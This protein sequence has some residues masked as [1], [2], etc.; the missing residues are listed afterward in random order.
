[1]RRGLELQPRA[2]LNDVFGTRIA[3]PSFRSECA[4]LVERSDIGCV[5][6]TTAIDIDTGMAV[7]AGNGRLE[8]P[9]RPGAVVQDGSRFAL[10][11]SPRSWLIQCNFAEERDL[12]RDLNSGYPDKLLYAVSFTDALCWLELSGS[13]ALDLL[14][15]GGFISLERAGLEIGHAKRTLIAQVSAI[16]MR[17]DATTWLV[18]IERSRAEYFCEWLSAA[19]NTL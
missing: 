9:R 11:L 7:K 12:V 19:A 6:V 8:L 5:L 2:A 15:E 1:M 17:Q 13:G 10:W 3:V 16:V 18:A 4:T 14:L